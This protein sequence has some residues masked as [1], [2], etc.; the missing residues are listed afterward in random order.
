MKK[1]KE[2]IKKEI[3][4]KHFFRIFQ[5]ENII[6]CIDE[7][8][9]D[10][11]DV[12]FKNSSKLMGRIYKEYDEMAISFPLDSFSMFYGSIIKTEHDKSKDFILF[13]ENNELFC[14]LLTELTGY[15]IKW[16]E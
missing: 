9:L 3:I 13:R 10:I 4:R 14:E 16:V 5:K 12:Y 7:P 11:L 6:I 2:Q 15:N 1:D 8:P